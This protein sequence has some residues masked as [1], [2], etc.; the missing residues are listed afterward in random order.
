MLKVP[1]EAVMRDLIQ[2]L[3]SEIDL[4]LRLSSYKSKSPE[5]LDFASKEGIEGD[6][7]ARA[8]FVSDYI[9]TASEVPSGGT[10]DS[11]RRS[12]IH[13]FIMGRTRCSSTEA[14]MRMF[15]FAYKTAIKIRSQDLYMGGRGL[16][17][18]E[19]A[20]I[21][22]KD[23]FLA[24]Y[25]LIASE[26][27]GAG[28]C[29]WELGILSAA[30]K[31][32]YPDA[33]IQQYKEA[34]HYTDDK[35][36]IE[37]SWRLF[38]EY[39]SVQT[40]KIDPKLVIPNINESQSILLLDAR[41]PSLMSLWNLDSRISSLEAGLP[42][43]T[44]SLNQ[45]MDNMELVLVKASIDE[46]GEH[47]FIIRDPFIDSKP[48]FILKTPAD[49][50]NLSKILTT[51]RMRGS[52][53][54]GWE[55]VISGGKVKIP[56]KVQKI[57]KQPVIPAV[58][59]DRPRKGGFFSRIKQALFG[60]KEEIT[61]QEFPI[62]PKPIKKIKKERK[63]PPFIANNSYLAHGIT[64]DAV[65]D[66][67]I[68]ELFDTI[69]ETN[70]HILGAFDSDFRENQTYFSAKPN[71][72]SKIRPFLQSLYTDISKFNEAA[73]LDKPKVLIEEVFF[74]TEDQQ[75]YLIS[76]NGNQERIVGTIATSQ[77]DITEWQVRGKEKEPLL[78][79]SLHMRTK[80]FLN[81]RR[82]TKFSEAVERIYGPNFD[83]QLAEEQSFH[84][85]F[86]KT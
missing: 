19:T 17:P 64:V 43:L 56:E 4:D 39:M 8:L 11:R 37:Y 65:S 33:E 3:E 84:D 30:L 62:Q 1:N 59:V 58:Q 68:Y 71:L 31:R 85:V 81:A 16:S 21:R 25:L 72:H 18:R 76:L 50:I 34:P 28:P 44:K 40:V 45:K 86:I 52:E 55:K 32:T 9:I 66:L 77:P 57:T 36:L 23:S 29:G 13:S 47:F 2:K 6:D 7:A 51:L 22:L 70:Y 24:P 63:R 49:E 14:L 78:R 73:F 60:K 12:V 53:H 80:Q 83:I 10:D 20:L 5:L 26:T 27:L 42:P 79:R 69:R 67:D 38:E 61:G 82:H 35:T 74:M 41:K 46:L 54:N 75:R 48:I 15:Y